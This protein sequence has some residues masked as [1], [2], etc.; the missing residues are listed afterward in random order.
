MNRG[1]RGEKIFFDDRSR[2]Y[3]VTILEEKIFQFKQKLLAFCIMDNHYH[4]VMQNTS[5]KFSDLLKQL[6]GQYGM[7]YRKRRGGIGYVFQSRFKSTLIQ[8]DK[9]LRMAIIYVLLNPVRKGL[10]E[11]PWEYSWSSINEYFSGG[12]S[13]IVDNRFVE[14]LFES[15]RIMNG[16]LKE[17]LRVE[18]P[19][20]HTRMGEIL[21][22]EAF[23]KGSSRK[24]DRRKENGERVVDKSH[25]MRR[26]DG[27]FERADD[28]IASFENAKG[29]KIEELDL[30]SHRGKVLRAELLVLLKDEAGLP[31]SKIIEYPLFQSLK[32]SS[33]GQLYRRAKGKL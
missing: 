13:A 29:I 9:Y 27:L 7:Y 18:L 33:L 25:R 14:E 30:S 10:V 22:D 11:N 19:V 20:R 21:G 15:E 8:E 6:N 16:L 23:Q 32:Y 3:F 24:Y 28:V 4:L 26:S 17:W 2:A 12:V 31:Y 5:G 1:V